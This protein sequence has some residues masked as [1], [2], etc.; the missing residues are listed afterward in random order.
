[1]CCLQLLVLFIL[2]PKMQLPLEN[3]Y[4]VSTSVLRTNFELQVVIEE[5]G[6]RIVGSLALSTSIG[7]SVV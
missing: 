2:L 4:L 7:K 6:N 5:L 3:H 1:M